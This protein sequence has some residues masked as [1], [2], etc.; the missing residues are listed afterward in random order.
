MSR[1]FQLPFSSLNRGQ[2]GIGHDVQA[3]GGIEV[4][5][6]DLRQLNHQRFIGSNGWTIKRLFVFVLSVC[7]WLLL[8]DVVDVVDVMFSDISL[9]EISLLFDV[10]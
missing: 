5:G 6:I 3:I 1:L 4:D 2:H 10:M 9:K 7:C 8:V